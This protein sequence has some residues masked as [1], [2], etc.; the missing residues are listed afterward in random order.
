MQSKL[1]IKRL[2]KALQQETDIDDTEFLT[3]VNINPY[4]GPNEKSPPPIK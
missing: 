2:G 3:D 4:I 1:T